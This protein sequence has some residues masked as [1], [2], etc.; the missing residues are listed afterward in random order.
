[1]DRKKIIDKIRKRKFF[2]L[3]D[4]G[5]FQGNFEA[6]ILKPDGLY[7]A[8]GWGALVGPEGPY[9]LAA[10]KKQLQDECEDAELSIKNETFTSIAIQSVIDAFN[11]SGLKSQQPFFVGYVGDADENADVII[12]KTK[13]DVERKIQYELEMLCELSESFDDMDDE[14]LAE[15]AEQVGVKV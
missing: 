5:S 13:A 4:V 14:A 9:E 1:M 10:L 3:S 11:K 7:T 6:T 2:I 8:V 15:F 12:G